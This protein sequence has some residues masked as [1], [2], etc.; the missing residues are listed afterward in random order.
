MGK[1]IIIL[2]KSSSGKDTIYKRLKNETKLIEIVPY[3][4]RPM[5]EGE[6]DGKDYFFVDDEYFEK[7][8]SKVIEKRTYHTIKGDWTYGELFDHQIN[9]ND[10]NLNYLFITTLEGFESFLN[11]F[12]KENIIPIYIDLDDGTRLE[13]ALLREKSQKNPNYLELCR[14]FLADDKDF[15]KENLERLNISKKFINNSLDIVIS[16]IKDYLNGLDISV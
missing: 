9:L 13:R 3:T 12:G 4:T 14:R 10:D 1:F 11:Y 2:G 6:V 7:N 5:R 16:E 8:A 15:S